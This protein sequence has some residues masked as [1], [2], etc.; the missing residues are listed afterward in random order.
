MAG[1]GKNLL[2]E[3]ERKKDWIFSIVSTVNRNK[4]GPERR[5]D[6]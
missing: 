3:R 2:V 1:I 6:G 5:V 4:T